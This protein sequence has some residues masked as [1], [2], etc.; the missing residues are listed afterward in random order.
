MFYFF[1][2]IISRLS[3]IHENFVIFYVVLI[4]L[5]SYDNGLVSVNYISINWCLIYFGSLALKQKFLK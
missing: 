1:Y 5:A 3:E 2:F 4:L